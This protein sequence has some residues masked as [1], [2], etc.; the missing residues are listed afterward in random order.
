MSDNYWI[1]FRIAKRGD[2]DQRYEALG[3]AVQA[4]MSGGRW[5]KEPS[6]FYAFSS[7]LDIDA[8]ADR[9]FKAVDA[10]TDVVLIA[11]IGFKSYRIIGGKDEDVLDFFPEVKEVA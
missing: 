10:N 4:V 7:A 8:V 9:V 6:S 5:W 2:Y 3:Q 11:R 1:T